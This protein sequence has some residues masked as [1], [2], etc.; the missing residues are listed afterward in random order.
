[1]TKQQITENSYFERAEMIRK[2][3]GDS[4]SKQKLFSEI[5]ICTAN[6]VSDKIVDKKIKNL[7]QNEIYDTINYDK[8]Q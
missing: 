4:I 7:I 5:I 1:M 8:Y 2:L 3:I 6:I